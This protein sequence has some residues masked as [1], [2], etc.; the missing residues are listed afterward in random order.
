LPSL[1]YNV[2]VSVSMQHNIYIILT[3]FSPSPSLHVSA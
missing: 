2:T 3:F 1:T